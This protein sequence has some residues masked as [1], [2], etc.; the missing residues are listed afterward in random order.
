[1][2][3]SSFTFSNFDIGNLLDTYCRIQFLMISMHYPILFSD[4][5]IW[6]V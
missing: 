4:E 6:S 3:P 1:M 2:D 5:R